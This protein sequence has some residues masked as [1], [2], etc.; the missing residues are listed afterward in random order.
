MG[1]GPE[2]RREGR[3]LEAE[4]LHLAGVTFRISASQKISMQ[5]R[6]DGRPWLH[7][8]HVL[9]AYHPGRP[10]RLQGPRRAGHAAPHHGGR[11]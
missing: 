11:L 4:L 6:S 3:S 7:Q 8:R 5:W 9:G 1:P 10:Q 2:E